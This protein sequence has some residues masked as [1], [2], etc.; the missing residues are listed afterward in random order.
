MKR[1]PDPLFPLV[2]SFFRDHLQRVRGASRHTVLAYRDALRLFFGFVADS[3]GCPMSSLRVDHVTAEHVLAFL[4]HLESSRQNLPSTRNLRLTALR[5]FCRHLLRH[6]PTRAGQYQRVLS[7]PAKKTPQ[8]V[9]TYLEPEEVRVLL[10]QP[11]LRKRAEAR[12]HALLLFLYNTGAR[13]SEALT[14]C[15]GDLQLARPFQVQ[16]HGKGRKK[17]ICPLWQDTA[18]AMKR[19]LQHRSASVDEHVFTSTRGTPLSR[20]GAN[21]ILQ[22]HF[23]RAIR[24]LPALRRKHVTPHGLRHSCAVAMLQAGIDLS[25]IRD[26]LGHESIATTGRY[27]KT[28]L[29]MKRRVLE[30]FWKRSGLTGVRNPAWRPNNDLLSFLSSL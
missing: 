27:T 16:L 15:R 3:S 2:E 29:Q 7:L 30:A 24:A 18:A 1:T 6:D 23:R 13:I 28:N 4:E 14:V 25:V 5:S 21:Y 20:D 9:V 12:D 10:R 19:L 11:D 26:Y 8:A 17:R 22:K